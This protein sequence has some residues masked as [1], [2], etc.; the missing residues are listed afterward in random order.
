MTTTATPKKRARADGKQSRNEGGA[1]KRQS[2]LSFGQPT[3]RNQTLTLKRT[4]PRSHEHSYFHASFDARLPIYLFS[5]VS[6]NTEELCW[7]LDNA[8]VE[9]YS[10][11]NMF[12]TRVRLPRRLASAFDYDYE[13]PQL[14][15]TTGNLRTSFPKIG[16]RE[17][18]QTVSVGKKA[19]QFCT[20]DKGKPG[21]QL[22]IRFTK[23]DGPKRIYDVWPRAERVHVDLQL[24]CSF[25]FYQNLHAAFRQHAKKV[26]DGGLIFAWHPEHNA[27]LVRLEQ[28]Q[29]DHCESFVCH[30]YALDAPEGSPL[31]LTC[32]ERDAKLKRDEFV[33]LRRSVREEQV[34]YA[35]MD[36]QVWQ[37]LPV[38]KRDA[39]LLGPQVVLSIVSIQFDSSTITQ[40]GMRPKILMVH[41]IPSH[42]ADAH[43][44]VSTFSSFD[45]ALWASMI[46]N[47]RL[48]PMHQKRF[49]D[50]VPW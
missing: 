36:A 6:A 30:N 2:T 1:P 12:F 42:E 45:R 9:V 41:A 34:L 25:S 22:A 15:F 28:D 46:W 19:I 11:A 49:Q 17:T 26:I 7:K 8:T 32:E 16:T 48:R 47:A 39:F 4:V 13:E 14:L 24:F 10:S 23:L 20:T 43:G 40:Q 44:T 27:S 3:L 33:T 29:Q 35:A 5:Y 18:T 50:L 38:W 21:R 31:R 37:H